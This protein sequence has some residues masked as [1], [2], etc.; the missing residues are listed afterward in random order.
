MCYD[1]ESGCVSSTSNAQSERCWLK[2]SIM[3]YR[4]DFQ[5]C[6]AIHSVERPNPEAQIMY[7]D[8]G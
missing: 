1:M 2:T 8:D 6:T 4:N 5:V 7:D 3:Q